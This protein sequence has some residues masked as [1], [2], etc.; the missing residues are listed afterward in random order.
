MP[1]SSNVDN[2]KSNFSYGVY[3]SPNRYEIEI[4]PPEGINIS[5]SKTNGTIIAYPTFM[6]LPTRG[7]VTQKEFLF[8]VERELPVGRFYE[9]S[10]IIN[11]YETEGQP[12]RKLF[13]KWMD[14]IIPNSP[15]I[16]HDYRGDYYKFAY[17][18]SMIIKLLTKSDKEGSRYTLEEIYPS[19]ILP[20]EYSSSRTN[21]LSELTI[22]FNYKSYF[23]E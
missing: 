18:T 20:T 11:F 22:K 17:Q 12:E 15:Y 13:E 3:Q 7:F 19:E 2:F 5:A 14:S 9:N 23:I 6:T 16:N 8:G 21:V 10:I 1:I 4:T